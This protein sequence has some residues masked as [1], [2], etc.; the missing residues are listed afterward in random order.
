[1]TRAALLFTLLLLGACSGQPPEPNYYLLRSDGDLS[2][3][4]LQ[5]ADD[6]A[7]GKVS[8]APYIDQRGLLVET[9][10]G[11]LRPARYNLWAEPVYEGISLFLLKE[12]AS[13]SGDDLLPAVT[14]PDLGAINVRIDQLH[15]TSDGHAKLVAYWWLERGGELVSAHQFADLRPLASDGYGALV[16]AEKELLAM[17]A[18][19]I[20]AS[21]A[22]ARAAA[23]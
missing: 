5:P 19:E 6:F 7:L 12:I 10:E 14:N 15:G 22:T 17:L 21:L 8:I 4:T 20:A 1:M 3:R 23:E 16:A 11:D 18:G 13:Q 2:T 9:P